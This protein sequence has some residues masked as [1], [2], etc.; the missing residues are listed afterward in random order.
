MKIWIKLIQHII[1]EW[2]EKYPK[3][4]ELTPS[5]DFGAISDYAP[6]LLLHNKADK[7][8]EYFTK[9]YLNEFQKYNILDILSFLNRIIISEKEHISGVNIINFQK[10]NYSIN[11]LTETINIYSK[12][13]NKK[14]IKILEKR[15][16]EEKK[17]ERIINIISSQLLQADIEYKIYRQLVK[18]KRNNVNTFYKYEKI[19]T[20]LINITLYDFINII[21]KV[22][23]S[24]KDKNK[25]QKI[26]FSALRSFLYINENEEHRKRIDDIYHKTAKNIG[27]IKNIRNNLTAHLDI[28]LLDINKLFTDLKLEDIRCLLDDLLS[29]LNIFIEI[30]NNLYD[31]NINKKFYYTIQDE[32]TKISIN[33]NR[34]DNKEDIIIQKQKEKK[35]DKEI[36]KLI[37]RKVKAKIIF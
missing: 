32:I 31:K 10:I 12:T 9:E 26:S 14:N 22:T 7:I 6:F 2:K 29:S 13:N 36:K 37:K 35:H 19:F 1:R 4:K 16:E 8:D 25:K 30:Y 24:N 27:K 3:I 33:L 34:N 17:I 5:S 23:E 11:C 28:N 21:Y 20:P 18:T 15:N